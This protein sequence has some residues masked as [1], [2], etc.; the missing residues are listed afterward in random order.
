ML[1]LVYFTDFISCF[2]NHSQQSSLKSQTQTWLFHFSFP[3]K[4]FLSSS[5][6]LKLKAGYSE[7]NVSVSWGLGPAQ[8]PCE[9]GDWRGDRTACR[10][11][12]LVFPVHFQSTN[13]LR[14]WGEKQKLGRRDAD[15]RCGRK[16]EG[17]SSLWMLKLPP[18][19]PRGQGEQ[20]RIKNIEKYKKRTKKKKD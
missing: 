10:V 12:C 6:I 3:T 15:G 7:T 16:R 9:G 20:R 2:M 13:P 5:K 11:V 18:L 4:D 17:R 1:Y 14:L 19:A 8:W